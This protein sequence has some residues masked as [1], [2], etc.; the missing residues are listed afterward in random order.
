MLLCK[1]VIQEKEAMTFKSDFI[2]LFNQQF[3]TW[4][5]RTVCGNYLVA[6][7]Y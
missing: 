5:T 6:T 2:Y 3:I 4:G 7:I 1:M